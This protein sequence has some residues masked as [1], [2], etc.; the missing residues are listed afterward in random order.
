MAPS[1]NETRQIDDDLDDPSELARRYEYGDG[2]DRDEEK[3]FKLYLEAAEDGYIPAMHEVAQCYERGDGVDRDEEKAFKWYLKA[4]E[5][6]DVAAISEVAER[7]ET[8]NGVQKNMEKASEWRR[9]ERL[10]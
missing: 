3:A 10:N 6:Y 7:Y 9:I 1:N 2:V 5:S 4:A 8:G